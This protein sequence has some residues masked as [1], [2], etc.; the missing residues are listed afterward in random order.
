MISQMREDDPLAMGASLMFRLDELE[1][2]NAKLKKKAKALKAELAKKNKM[3]SVLKE[4]FGTRFGEDE[5]AYL[6]DIGEYET[7]S[8]WLGDK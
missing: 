1:E 7:I 8:E 2:K 4:L 3:L 6:K 5:I